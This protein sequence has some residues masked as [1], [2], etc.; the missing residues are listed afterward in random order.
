MNKSVSQI[1]LV[2]DNPNLGIGLKDFPEMKG[3]QVILKTDGISGREATLKENFDCLLLDII[4]TINT[5]I[6]IKENSSIQ[7]LNTDVLLV[8]SNKLNHTN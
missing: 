8:N 1:L 6:I 7:I 4:L 5:F 3:S 2:E